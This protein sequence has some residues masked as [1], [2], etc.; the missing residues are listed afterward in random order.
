MGTWEAKLLTQDRKYEKS[1][2]NYQEN[3]VVF[4]I[5]YYS[6]WYIVI[7]QVVFKAGPKSNMLT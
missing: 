5:F 7:F 4:I 2:G 1:Y 3:Q 6:E